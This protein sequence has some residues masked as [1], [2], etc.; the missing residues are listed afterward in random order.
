MWYHQHYVLCCVNHYVLCY[1]CTLWGILG[2]LHCAVLIAITVVLHDNRLHF[3]WF[4]Y[5]DPQA[6]LFGRWKV[7]GVVVRGSI[8]YRLTNPSRRL[9]LGLVSLYDM[10]PLTTTPPTF[11]LPNNTACDLGWWVCM[12]C[13]PLLPLPRPSTSQ[14][15]APVPRSR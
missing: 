15:I 9:R 8:S 12:I 4:I 11:H 1:L 14:I 5:L 13:Y 7:G 6:L 3:F 10:L 2:W